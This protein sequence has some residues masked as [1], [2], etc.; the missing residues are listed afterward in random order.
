MKNIERLHFLR[1][2]ERHEEW[3]VMEAMS[4]SNFDF[5]RKNRGFESWVVQY[6]G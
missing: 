1:V 5:S 6:G 2:H 3:G 4:M